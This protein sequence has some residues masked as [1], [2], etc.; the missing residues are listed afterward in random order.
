MY[1]VRLL[2]AKV[3]REWTSLFVSGKPLYTEEP[4]EATSSSQEPSPE[5][6]LEEERQLLLD[7]GDFD[8]YRVSV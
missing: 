1:V 5:Q 8:E 7:E 6:L 4:A 2:P 3:V